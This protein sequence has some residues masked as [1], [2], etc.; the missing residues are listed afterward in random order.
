MSEPTDT[1]GYPTRPRQLADGAQ[2]FYEQKSGLEVYPGVCGST[3]HIP[4]RKLCAAVDRHR[5]IYR[6]NNTVTK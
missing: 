3:V 1:D 5:R 4:W 6:G 2:W